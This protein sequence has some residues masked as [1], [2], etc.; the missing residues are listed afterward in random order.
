MQVDHDQRAGVLPE[1]PPDGVGP[2]YTVLVSTAIVLALGLTLG[3]LAWVG[4]ASRHAPEQAAVV[5]VDD[6][7]Q[8][9]A[10]WQAA[11]VRGVALV[12]AS[13]DFGYM[14]VD[15]RTIPRQAGWPI[16]RIDLSSAWLRSVARPN[17]VWVAT[18]TGIARSVRYLV[19]SAS[20]QERV[21]EGREQGFPGIAA[22]GGSITAN[23]EGFLRYIDDELKGSLGTPAVLNIDASYFV[24]GTPDELVS[25]LGDSIG[26]FRLITVDRATDATDL[27]ASARVGADAMAALLRQRT[28]R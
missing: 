3:A 18:K 22:D 7:A 26:S 23:D 15:E 9:L 14:P 17:I 4:A 10:A 28:G 11:D 1:L 19:P 16:G 25:Q 24:D 12:D 21:R 5:V 2:R 6:S 20:L 13:R 27:P 8:L